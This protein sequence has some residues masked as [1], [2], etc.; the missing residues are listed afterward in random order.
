MHKVKTLALVRQGQP[1]PAH[2]CQQRACGCAPADHQAFLMINT[3]GL[4][5]INHHAFPLQQHM[6]TPL[7]EASPV[8]VKLPQPQGKRGA[9]FPRGTV[10][11]ALAIRINE[12]A[13]PPLAH[14]IMCLEM[15][16]GFTLAADF[17]FLLKEDRWLRRPSGQRSIVQHRIW[18]KPLE[19][20]ALVLKLPQPPK[21]RRFRHDVSTCELAR[22][23]PASDSFNT[24][25]I[26]SSENLVCFIACASFKSDYKYIR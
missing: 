2:W 22:L 15:C 26:Y 16:T 23:A 25:M 3:L 10:A 13:R 8:V 11:H 19:F 6:D 5:V 12:T 17:Y 4:L 1:E 24:P 21:L 14:P 7:G 9:E 18:Q 20:R